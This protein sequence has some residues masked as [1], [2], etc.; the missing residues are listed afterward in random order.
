[1]GHFVNHVW[2]NIMS[3]KIE[4]CNKG[5]NTILEAILTKTFPPPRKKTHLAISKLAKEINFRAPN[6][7]QP[8]D[9]NAA[10]IELKL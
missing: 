9:A 4:L 1:M 7:L 6:M 5:G 10:K 8:V 3:Y 2:V